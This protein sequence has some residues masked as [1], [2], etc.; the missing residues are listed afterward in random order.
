VAAAAFLVYLPALGG[1]YTLDDV[2]AVRDDARLRGPGAVLGS[3][4]RPYLT[5][6]PAARSPYRPITSLSY[7]LN[8][9]VGNGDPF[10]FHLFNVGAHVV[11]VLLLLS[12]LLALGAPSGAA[13]VAA[14]LFAV[15]PVHVEAVA[16]IVGRGDVLMALF[17]L[18]GVRLH[19]SQR[20]GPLAR[21]LGVSLAYLLAVGA[22]EN[23]YILPVLI[24]LVE[25]LRVRPP[26]QAG[27]LLRRLIGTWPTLAAMSVAFLAYLVARRSVLGSI[28][29]LDVAAY[30]AILPDWLRITTAVAN[31][32][33]VARLLFLPSD[34]SWHYGPAVLMP[35]GLDSLRFWAGLATLVAAILITVGSR[36]LGPARR[37]VLLGLGWIAASFILLSNLVLPMPTWLAERTLYL[38]T[39][40]GAML[41]AGA[42]SALDARGLAVRHRTILAVA[43]FLTIGGA[44]Q[45]W[46]YSKA[47][48]TTD[49]LYADLVERHPESFHAPWWIGQRLVGTGELERG[50]ELLATAVSLNPNMLPVT[51]D[52][53][54][55]L[56]MDGR[57]EEAESRLR[58][59]P[60]GLHPS[61]P[62]YLAQSLILQGRLDE[63]R[64]VVDD[65]LLRFPGDPRLEGQRSQ[66]ALPDS[67]NASDSDTPAPA[68]TSASVDMP[69]L[70]I[71]RMR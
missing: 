33:V 57:A 26:A 49:T 12:T 39:A 67:A 34:L 68:D 18:L 10:V 58:P 36:R 5:D 37:W 51:L 40:G 45:C 70:T 21:A 50:I 59:V 62:V 15:H 43:A 7:A 38:P 28:A 25:A 1:D 41:V 16:N 42:L 20:I 30:I 63:A 52:L 22:K 71:P 32:W 29:H 6:V 53:T 31:L 44:V 24:L 3:F 69:P 46:Q 65:G 55:A 61:V 64:D 13:G 35:A 19:L 60:R 14:L 2:A 17:C 4:T 8:W 66:L 27:S 47:W 54:R 11:T 48:R 23:G 56:L 9:R